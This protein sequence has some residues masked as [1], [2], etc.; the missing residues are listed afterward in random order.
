MEKLL[1]VPLMMLAVTLSIFLVAGTANA[2]CCCG[3]HDCA[4][5]PDNNLCAGGFDGYVCGDTVTESCTFEAGLSCPAGHG[6]IVGAESITIDGDGYFISGAKACIGGEDNHAGIYMNKNPDD[7]L[8]D[9][10]IKNLEVKNFCHGI[11]MGKSGPTSVLNTTGN[12]IECCEIHDNGDS[13]VGGSQTQGIKWNGV[14][15]SVIKNCKVY[16]Q[17]GDIEAS[18]PP[19]AFGVYLCKGNYNE[20][21]YNEVY[22]NKK[23]GFF[24]RCAP[25]HTWLHHNYAHN[26]PFGGIRGQCIKNYDGLVEY[27]Y[28]INNVGEGGTAWAGEYGIMFGGADVRPNVVRYNTCKWNRVGIEFSREAWVGELWENTVCENTEWDIYV[29]DWAAVIGDYNTCDTAYNYT[30]ASATSGCFYA[31]DTVVDTDNDGIRDTLP[32]TGT[33][34]DNC[35]LTENPGQLDSDRDGY[36]NACDCDL[37]NDDVVNLTDLRMFKDA[38]RSECVGNGCLDADLNGDGK[39]DR[40]DYRIFRSRY[41][42][43]APFE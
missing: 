39:V 42:D 8:N 40:K 20:W 6:L 14:S 5:A 2:V 31:C 37:N 21:C 32:H 18:G 33:P 15:D 27:N 22:N 29:Q 19:G 4:G 30:D 41:G 24:M 11:W 3:G 1:K 13:T 12:T 36:G 16:N 7:D 38:W 28:C 26:N 17:E 23:A 25:E 43:T 34:L 9:V 10:T 35:R